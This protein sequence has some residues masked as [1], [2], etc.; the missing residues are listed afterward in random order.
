M[1]NYK[2]SSAALNY[3]KNTGSRQ[4]DIITKNARLNFEQGEINYLE[5]AT[6]MNQA[7]LI[8]LGQLDALKNFNQAVIYLEYLLAE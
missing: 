5:W 7:V 2:K 1:E 8:R 3:Y 4:A 6:L